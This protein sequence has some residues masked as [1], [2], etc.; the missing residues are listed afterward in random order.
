MILSQINPHFLYN[1]LT[2]IARL[3]EKD[4]P[5]AKETTLNFS[6]YLR[7]N[8]NALNRKTPI[9]FEKELDH[10][11]KYLAIEQVRY[12]DALKVV[13]DIQAE[14]FLLP[15]L[16]L[17]P[18]VENAVKHGVGMKEE[19]GT[20]TLATRETPDCFLV[21]VTDDGVGFDP[22]RPKQDGRTHVGIANV[23]ARPDKM[24]HASLSLESR[25]G[26][27]TVATIRIPKEGENA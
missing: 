1:T 24:M 26:A 8:M 13:Y 16:S 10:V 27:G 17:Q 25:M 12:A 23:R 5:M 18:L 4:P 20:I 6:A 15:A 3:C 14:R 21:T 7:S 11:K 9:A 22:E 19:G 2:A